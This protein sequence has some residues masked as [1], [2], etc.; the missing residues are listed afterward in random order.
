MVHSEAQVNQILDARKLMMILKKMIDDSQSGDKLIFHFV[1]HS[2]RKA[3][4]NIMID[5]GVDH[6]GNPRGWITGNDT[7]DLSEAIS[8]SGQNVHRIF[9][10]VV[11]TDDAVAYQSWSHTWKGYYADFSYSF[12]RILDRADNEG[13]DMLTNYEMIRSID[14]ML[15]QREDIQVRE[16]N[17]RKV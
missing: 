12:M 14:E 6:I 7:L 10:S 1:G 3:D 11:D 4:G 5:L 16:G 8:T 9:Y 15:I 17:M 13:E 2:V